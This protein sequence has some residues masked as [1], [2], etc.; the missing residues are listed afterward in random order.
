M[1]NIQAEA[2]ERLA[3]EPGFIPFRFNCG[4]L[5]GNSYSYAVIWGADK[6]TAGVTDLGAL[7][8]GQFMIWFEVKQPGEKHLDSQ[9]KF[10]TEV[11][12]AGGRVITIRTLDDLET[13]IQD[14]RD[15]YGL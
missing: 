12:A 13:A 7:I 6:S 15:Y 2:Y 3:W 8:H 14:L 5:K 11:E 1:G 10:A 4:M 9:K